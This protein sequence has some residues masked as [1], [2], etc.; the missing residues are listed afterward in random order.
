MHTLF[1]EDE[2]KDIPRETA[3][4]AIGKPELEMAEKIISS[5]VKPFNPEEF[6]DEYQGRLR[7]LIESK[8]EGREIAAPKQESGE[9]VINLMDALKASMADLNIGTS[10]GRG[11]KAAKPRRKTGS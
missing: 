7:E 2:V 3:K 6:R 9:S 11:G 5:M 4:P 10:A 8:I 1:Y